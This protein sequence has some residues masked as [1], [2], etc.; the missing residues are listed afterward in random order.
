MTDPHPTHQRKTVYIKK[1]FQFNF[2]LKFCLILLAGIVISTVLIFLF[3]QDTLTS[4][5]ENSRL[6]I[7]N[8]NQAILPTI[9]V[10]N[11][12]TLGIITLAAILVTLYISHRI[13]GPLFRFEADLKKIGD[14]DLR[15]KINLRKK[16]Q[17]SEMAG[18]INRMTGAMHGKVSDIS[19]RADRILA[20]ADDEKIP[21]NYERQVAEL[22]AAVN[23]HFSI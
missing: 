22:K 19:D 5:F 2:I 17:F 1:R 23:E 18:H 13:A 8:T 16:D 12:I 14:G 20:M 10:T 4:S 21:E 3:S 9:L 6:V 15:V 7:R 11:L